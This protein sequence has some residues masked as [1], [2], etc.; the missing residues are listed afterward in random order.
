MTA[1]ICPLMHNTIADS[2][3][4]SIVSKSSKY[5]Y[6]LGKTVPYSLANG[7]E[8]VEVPLPTYKYELSTRRDILSLKQITNND[9]SYV[10]PRIDWTHD[11]IYDYY[12]DS[13]TVETPAYSGT[14]GIT[15]A[16]GSIIDSRY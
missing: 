10:V 16:I 5:Y 9:V 3:Y 4:S 12:D 8:Q 7:V 2:I 15:Y 6:F 1:A 11:E 13:Y 14:T